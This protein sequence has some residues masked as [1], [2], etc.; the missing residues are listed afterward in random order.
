MRNEM[1]NAMVLPQRPTTAAFA[2]F[3]VFVLLFLSGLQVQAQATSPRAGEVR[4][5]A[6]NALMTQ[7]SI[8][9]DGLRASATMDKTSRDIRM[10]VAEKI[11]GKWQQKQYDVDVLHALHGQMRAELH[12]VRTGRLI[13]LDSNQLKAS[14]LIIPAIVIVGELLLA[15]LIALSLAVV[16]AG[17]TYV[18][19]SQA[20]DSLRKRNHEHYAAYLDTKRGVF[21]GEPLSRN[22]AALRLRSTANGVN[23]TWSKTLWAARDIAFLAHGK[24]PVGPEIHGKMPLYQWHFHPHNRIGGHAFY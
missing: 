8:E 22:A 1:R 24:T 5:T 9:R 3:M 19:L 17:V 7:V 21:I 13:P 14:F 23:N 11:N 6:D 12:E 15:H 10:T 18:A 20:A 16:I 4:V 2:L